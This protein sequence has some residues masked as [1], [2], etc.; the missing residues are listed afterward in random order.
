M[1]QNVTYQLGDFSDMICRQKDVNAN[2]RKTN[3]FSWTI[4]CELHQRNGY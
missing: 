1:T 3:F 4:V 2:S